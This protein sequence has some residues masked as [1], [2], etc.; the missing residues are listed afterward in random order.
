MAMM[1][2]LAPFWKQTES[3]RLEFKETL[4]K[5]DQVARTVV[6][7]AN[8]GG[9]KIVFGVKNELREAVGIPDDEIFAL[10]E[11]ISNL[12]FDRCTPI[13]IPEIY[14][15][16]VEGTN[17][18]VVEI[19]PGNQ[20]PY[21]LKGK[22]RRKGTYVR[23]GST[24][25]LASREIL[26]SLER[27]KRM[28]SFDG[29]PIYDLAPEQI[30]LDRFKAEYQNATG[31]HADD[32][33]L[34]NMGLMAADRDRVYPT[35]AALLLSDSPERVQRF[36]YAKIECA[37]FK[38]TDTHLFLDQATIDRPIQA[39]IDPCMGFVK[40]NIALASRIGEIYREDRWEYPLLAVREAILNAIIHRDYSILGGDIKIAIFDDMLEVTSPGPLP[41]TLAPEDLGTGRSEIRNRVLAPIF[42]DLKLIEAWGTGIAR[43]RR[44]LLSYPEIELLL[45]E[46]GYAFQARFRKKDG[47]A[48]SSWPGA[49]SSGAERT[50]TSSGRTTSALSPEA[51]K[52][53]AFCQTE[54]SAREMM[55]FLGLGRRESFFSR[56][57]R[58]LMAGDLIRM[59]IPDKPKS[60]RQRYRLTPKGRA[61][62]GQG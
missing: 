12:I 41:D 53:L 15:Q 42:K 32:Q 60:P 7:F 39:A 35:N 6:G 33:H 9:G 1:T 43:M 62:L 55:R 49:E 54:P 58:P 13:I 27:Q 30:D 36:P 61:A 23:V 26:E 17:L 3:R 29:L 50:S 31:R 28:L 46:V 8:G 14:I 25:R 44:E 20:K 40:K 48:V 34:V 21:Y 52:L 45:Q 56:Y 37:R 59:A 2:E 18:L 11:R 10:E 5:G 19:F 22:G 4:P 16:S 47:G 57:L 38:G 24:N 51:R